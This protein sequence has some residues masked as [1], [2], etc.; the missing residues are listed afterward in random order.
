MNTRTSRMSIVWLSSLCAAAG[1]A[2]CAS[3]DPGAD[4]TGGDA[5]PELVSEALEALM[6]RNSLPAQALA[7]GAL[8]E[9]RPLLDLLRSSALGDPSLADDLASPQLNANARSLLKYVVSCALDP[10]RRVSAW[11]GELGLCGAASPHGDWFERPPSAACQEVVSACVLARTNALGRKVRLSTRSDEDSA[12]FP[13]LPVVPV[14][15]EYR[16]AGDPPI[17][18]LNAPC[19]AGAAAGDPARDCGWA[20]R[21]VGTCTP[22]A[23]VVLKPGGAARASTRH[24]MVR[25]CNG[26]HGCD[27]RTMAPRPWYSGL[28]AEGVLSVDGRSG[29][30]REVSFTCPEPGVPGP[31][32]FAVMVASPHPAEAPPAT[33]DVIA[34]GAAAI[35]PAPEDKVFTFRE[36][37][38]YGN[39]FGAA[40]PGPPGEMLPNGQH[41]CYSNVWSRPMAHFTDRLCAGRDAGCFGNPPGAC[42]SSPAA[43]PRP[44]LA[45]VCKGEGNGSYY[46]CAAA[47]G[48]TP[49]NHVITVFLNHPCDLAGDLIRCQDAFAQLSPPGP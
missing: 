9:D 47:A 24:F 39:L 7:A 6:P 32:S 25:V 12:L 23:R 38:F 43:P 42:L 37:A 5:P 44:D 15:T 22:K 35:Y 46:G 40:N 28:I 10:G 2:G 18:S 48:R 36:G 49:W 20:G 41:A 34:A 33:A 31:S 1:A 29:T 8:L 30:T 19:A 11:E 27:H 26:I 21:H 14:E 16:D 4:W 13:L 17:K 3:W 45:R